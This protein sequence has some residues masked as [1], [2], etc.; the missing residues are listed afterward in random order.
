MNREDRVQ[1]VSI[2]N[3]VKKGNSIEL[4]YNDLLRNKIKRETVSLK[5]TAWR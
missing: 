4:I 3:I 1:T 2:T 5:A